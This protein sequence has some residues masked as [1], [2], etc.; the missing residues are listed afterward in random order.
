[1]IWMVRDLMG[2]SEAEVSD[3]L[4][5]QLLEEGY[6][7]VMG[8]RS[9][10]FADG[11][12]EIT[13]V[14]GECRYPLTFPVQSIT[15]ILDRVHDSYLRMIPLERLLAFENNNHRQGVPT[16]FALEEQVVTVSEGGYIDPYVDIYGDAG[17]R[18]NDT[19]LHFYP[20]PSSD[21]WEFEVWYKIPAMFEESDTAIPPWTELY[22]SIL[23][24]WVLHRLYERR[25]D[26]ES[27]G[28]YYTRF[29]ATLLDID[30]FYNDRDGT[31]PMVFGSG[32]IR[33]PEGH[34]FVVPLHVP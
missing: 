30:R 8:Y 3:R 28:Q 12:D 11:I 33:N 18:S 6:G 1:M 13:T 24:D 5:D 22:H 4:I 21:G 15:N 34:V 23:V 14:A 19:V 17:Y 31:K 27:S 25:R 29:G 7:K 2:V 20:A 26:F 9:W 16:V 32:F 10:P